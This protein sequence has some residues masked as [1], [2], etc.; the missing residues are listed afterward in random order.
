MILTGSEVGLLH[1]FAGLEDPGSDLYG[2]YYKA[3]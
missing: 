1:D 2:K 3:I